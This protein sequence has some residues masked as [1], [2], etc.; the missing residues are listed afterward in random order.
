MRNLFVLIAILFF[1]INYSA[2]S[3]D[4]ILLKTG[5]EIK[6]IVSEIDKDLIKYKK[7]ENPTGPVYSLKSTE[8]FMI[9]FE[10]GTKEIFNKEPEQKLT[11]VIE[12]KHRDSLILKGNQVLNSDG[13]ILKKDKLIT[14][15]SKESF[16]LYTSGKNTI[17]ASKIIYYG[18]ALPL[19]VYTCILLEKANSNYM[20]GKILGVVVLYSIPVWI[21][22][23]SG[24]RKIKESVILHNSGLSKPTSYKINVGISQ[25]G[26]AL[27]LTF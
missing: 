17:T 9:T 24:E 18:V 25:N 15:M 27:V 19:G 13:I 11:E 26:L 16:D 3:Q 2:Y 8:V 22:E 21:I 6:A 7:F 1:S 23:S 10:N 20:I 5:E 4:I 12:T 14:I